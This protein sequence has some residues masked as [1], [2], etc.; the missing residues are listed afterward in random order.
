MSKVYDRLLEIC[1]GLGLISLVG[2]LI[3]RIAP[4]LVSKLGVSPRG[5]L[6]LAGVLFLCAMATGEVKKIPPPA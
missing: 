5:G 2:S 3:L 6:I 1:W 4:G